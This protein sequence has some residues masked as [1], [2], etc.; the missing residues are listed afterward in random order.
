MTFPARFLVKCTFLIVFSSF[1]SVEMI[2]ASSPEVGR[3]AAEQYIQAKPKQKTRSTSSSGDFSRYLA[4]HVGHYFADRAYR[5]GQSQEDDVGRFQ[6]G[7]TYRLGEWMWSADFLV[8]VDWLSY[9]PN[10]Q[11]VSKLAFLPALF[12]PDAASGF[13]LYFGVAAGPSVFLKQISD[14]SSLALDYQ[15]LIGLRFFD[16]YENTGA[17]LETGLKNSLLLLSDGQHTDGVF[18]SLGAVFKF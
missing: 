4:V 2:N 13:P 17:F 3:K 12:L 9:K 14:E 11:T 18:V 8:R 5:W 7:F 6:A 15:L 1:I 16:L 10:D